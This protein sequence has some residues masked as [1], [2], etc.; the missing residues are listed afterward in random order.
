MP[1]SG[2]G[3]GATLKCS[4]V[5]VKASGAILPFTN[6]VGANY[7]GSY[8]IILSDVDNI[9]GGV[10]P[11]ANIWPNTAGVVSVHVQHYMRFT[12]AAA[13]R[14]VMTWSPDGADIPDFRVTQSQEF[15]PGLGETFRLSWVTMFDQFAPIGLGITAWNW[16]FV[17]GPGN[18]DLIDDQLD[19][20][21]YHT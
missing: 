3:G 12:A 2:G 20:L 16:F 10:A 7:L 21:I 13:G 15:T 9:L 11:F 14:Y 6:I 19:V 1:L 17:A 5:L 18:I 8:D 4:K